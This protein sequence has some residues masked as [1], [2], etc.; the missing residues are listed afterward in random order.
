MDNDGIGNR[1]H[2]RI[3]QPLDQHKFQTVSQIGDAY[4]PP[5][6]GIENALTLVEHLHLF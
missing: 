6:E 1:P 5:S 4:S 3:L 2:I